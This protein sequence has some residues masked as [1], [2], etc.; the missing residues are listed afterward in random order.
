MSLAPTKQASRKRHR[1]NKPRRE[2]TR[3]SRPSAVW[4]GSSPRS[5]SSD[6]DACVFLMR[7][8]SCSRGA[9]FDS[10]RSHEPTNSNSH[11][12]NSTFVRSPRQ[13]KAE[14]IKI[15]RGTRRWI[16]PNLLD[17]L[18]AKKVSLPAPKEAE[19]RET[20]FLNRRAFLDAVRGL[21]SALASRRSTAALTE[22][23]FVAQGS[24][25]GHAF[26]DSP[27]HAIL[28]TANRGEDRNASPRAL[29]APKSIPVQ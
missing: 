20:L 19:R 26:R 17:S 23:T 16:E 18:P 29:P 11:H 15:G 3:A 24:A 27:E 28:W 8:R 7:K 1:S 2:T 25:S 5:L 14:T 21:Q 10:C 12:R 4:C 6:D 22:G 13:W 9:L